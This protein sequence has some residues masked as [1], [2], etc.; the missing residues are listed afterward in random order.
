MVGRDCGTGRSTQLGIFAQGL[1]RVGDD[2]ALGLVKVGVTS[3]Q[4]PDDEQV[5]VAEAAN[6]SV[7]AST[8]AELRRDRPAG[9]RESL[10]TIMGRRR[11]VVT[12]E[13]EGT[14]AVRKR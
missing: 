8:I 12:D 7:Q 10:P 1:D 13:G 6:E 11:E 9:D 2:T 5:T 14:P 3:G 4:S